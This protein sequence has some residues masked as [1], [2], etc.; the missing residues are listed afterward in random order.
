MQQH[1]S[2]D[3][4]QF[5]YDEFSYFDQNCAEYGLDPSSVLPVERVSLS[6]T[7]PTISALKWGAADPTLVLLHGT[8]QNAHTWD[9][10]LCAMG[11]PAL[12]IDLPGHGH[13]DWRADR[14]YHPETSATTIAQVLESLQIG[15]FVLVGM[16]LGGLCANALT[17]RFA[18][19]VSSLLVVDITP[20]TTEA[21]ARSIMDF[22]NGPQSFASFDELLARTVEFNPTRS[23]SSLRRGIL[24]N[25]H[26]GQ[27]G[28]WQWNYDRG[29]PLEDVSSSLTNLW[30][31]VAA[32]SCPYA[33]ARGLLSPVVT[34]ADVA[35]L[36]SLQ[37]DARVETFSH[38]GHSIQGDEPVAL[39]ALIA[40]R[41]SHVAP[42][43]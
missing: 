30:A 41:M 16:S 26:R 29:E 8:A 37:P 34:D 12:A 20:G 19:L 23:V 36:M 22:V 15:P 42:D 4:P 38:S 25:A 2:P 5:V 9:T 27:D 17:A 14:N 35:H 7:G 10:V 40:E 39:A 11:V 1:L 21:G 6:T 13:S 43:T 24:H 18:D 31:D 32:I 33:L 3:D 28:S